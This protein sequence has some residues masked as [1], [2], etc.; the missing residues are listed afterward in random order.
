MIG[1]IGLSGGSFRAVSGDYER[2]CRLF[3]PLGKAN[4]A[5]RNPQ[6]VE[7][8]RGA[9][10]IQVASSLGQPDPRLANLDRLH[11]EQRRQMETQAD[12]AESACHFEAAGTESQMSRAISAVSEGSCLAKAMVIENVAASANDER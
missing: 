3:Q 6:T 10:G 12:S 11:V 7:D 8:Q 9:A 4:V 5:G 2:S 1:T